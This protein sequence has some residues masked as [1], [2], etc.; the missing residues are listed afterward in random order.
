MA[1]IRKPVHLVAEGQ[2]I[3][4]TVVNASPFNLFV[5]LVPGR[6][7]GVLPFDRTPYQEIARLY[8]V[9]DKVEVVVRDVDPQKEVVR[10]E[11]L[12]DPTQ[13]DGFWSKQEPGRA[14]SGLAPD[15]PRDSGSLDS[16]SPPA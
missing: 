8:R 10:L 11:M 2:V 1:E 6:L 9:G 3:V 12:P 5:E 16:A 4:G 15:R 13:Y 14:E 7:D